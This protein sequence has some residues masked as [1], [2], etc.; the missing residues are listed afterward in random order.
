MMK[1]LKFKPLGSDIF[2]Y[3]YAHDIIKFEETELSVTKVYFSFF[4]EY[5]MHIN[6][7]SLIKRIYEEES[8]KFEIIEIDNDTSHPVPTFG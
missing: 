3:L 7:E 6:A 1:I 2:L 5:E 4:E 8:E